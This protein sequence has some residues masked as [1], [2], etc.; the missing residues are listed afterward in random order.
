MTLYIYDTDYLTI[1]LWSYYVELYTSN[2][3]LS[4]NCSFTVKNSVLLK[5]VNNRTW[6][7]SRPS[8]KLYLRPSSYIYLSPYK[9][10]P[11]S[12]SMLTTCLGI[13]SK[14]NPRLFDLMLQES[15]FPNTAA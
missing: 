4:V 12:V 8:C 5:H 1:L 11:W 2:G 14:K 13:V 7:L 9:P 15:S 3:N 10:A 6:I